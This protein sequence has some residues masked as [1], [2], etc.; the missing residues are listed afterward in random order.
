M[1]AR[2]VLQRPVWTALTKG[3]VQRWL[4]AI[5]PV[6]GVLALAAAL[7]PAAPSYA[8]PP[9]ARQTGAQCNA[10]HTVYPQLTP[11]GRQ[12]KL[13]GFTDGDPNTAFYKKFGAWAQGSF[14][15]TNKDQAAPP[16]AGFGVN[17]NFAFDVA[18]L[19]FGGRIVDKLGAFVQGTYDGIGNVWSWDN[20]DVRFADQ[21]TIAGK[22]LAF[23]VSVNN[24]PTVTD[25]WNTVPAWSFP[26]DSSGLAPSPSAAP[27]IKDGLG[28]IVIG[29]SA[30]ADW[31]STIYA[32][33]GLYHTLT[34]SAIDALAVSPDGAPKSDG[35]VP[36]WRFAW[37]RDDGP[38]TFM[39]G[40]FGLHAAVYPNGDKSGGA[41][42]YTDLGFDAQYQYL[43]GRDSITVRAAL[44]HE[45]Q[46]LKGS[47]ALGGADTS[48]GS[49]NSFDVSAAYLYDK[50]YQATLGISHIW[51]G[52]DAALYGTGNGS[53]D[54]TNLT[55]QL[56]WLPLNKEPWTVYPWFNPR[57]TLQYVHHFKL[58]GMSHNASD[59][60]TLWLLTTATF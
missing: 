12:F 24:N 59:S 10:C 60:D 28:Q 37:H 14:T 51:G 54:S 4:K 25:P 34:R 48:G 41:D 30:Y 26:F 3:T 44:I 18:S 6:A 58:D 55:V 50:T 38:H 47:F 33:F 52:M 57:L 39:V 21:G 43:G 11:F 23:G 49:L 31:D 46:D 8:I 22:D 29:A 20:V 36:Y 32:E 56:D 9:Y 45:M 13:R 53:P 16:E 35:V 5:R 17:N 42:R 27:L 7:L 40:T 1:S 2:N 19:F 15:H